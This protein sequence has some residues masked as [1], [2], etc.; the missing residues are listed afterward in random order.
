[1]DQLEFSYP[2]T[3]KQVVE[4]N[5]ACLVIP[6]KVKHMPAVTLC[7]YPKEKKKKV[8][9]CMHDC[10]HCLI[11]YSSKPEEQCPSGLKG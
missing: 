5:G 1:M 3:E 8:Q 9:R 11:S 6:Y 7:T 10:A 2:A 4:H